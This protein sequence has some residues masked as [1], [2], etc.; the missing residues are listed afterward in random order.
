MANV[1]FYVSVSGHGSAIGHESLDAAR[2]AGA[3]L[4]DIYGNAKHARID[5]IRWSDDW[6]R[7]VHTDKGYAIVR[8]SDKDFNRLVDW[9]RKSGDMPAVLKSASTTNTRKSE[10]N[11]RRRGPTDIVVGPIGHGKPYA[12]FRTR[13]AATRYLFTI[14][15]YGLIVTDDG[16]FLQW[17]KYAGE[18]SRRVSDRYGR[19]VDESTVRILRIEEM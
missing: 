12:P 7:R 18:T 13:E 4:L 5:R 1:R 11:G 6:G 2:G 9:Y 16:G 8:R 17:R 19:P 15:R 3:S 14:G 10:K